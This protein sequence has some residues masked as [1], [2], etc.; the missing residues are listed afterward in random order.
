MSQVHCLLAVHADDS[1]PIGAQPHCTAGIR[2]VRQKQSSLG[3]PRVS[4]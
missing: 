3:V 4:R 2:T 1:P